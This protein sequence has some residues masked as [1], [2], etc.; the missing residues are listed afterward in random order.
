ME[1]L[2]DITSKKETNHKSKKGKEKEKEKEKGK[3][4]FDILYD[5]HKGGKQ[6]STIGNPNK[7]SN[8]G[9][10]TI[11]AFFLCDGGHVL[12]T[13]ADMVVNWRFKIPFI[14]TFWN[15]RYFRK[16]GHLNWL[17]DLVSSYLAGDKEYVE[18]GKAAFRKERGKKDPP[19]GRPPMVRRIRR[20]RISTALD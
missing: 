19:K 17:S 9:E 5:A 10:R 16:V 2:S 1:R 18:G 4:S 12:P 6:P 8:R 3:I 7:G 13:T 14:I 15:R 20:P 11:I